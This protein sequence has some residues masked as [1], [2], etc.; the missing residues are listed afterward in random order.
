MH[1]STVVSSTV[2]EIC[3]VPASL[4]ITTYRPNVE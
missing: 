3:A 2:A 4:S 1:A